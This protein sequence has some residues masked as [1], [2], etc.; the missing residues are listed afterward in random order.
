M[1]HDVFI[2]HSSA[3][4][5][6]ADAICH[7]LENNGIKCWIAPR[8]VTP[9]AEYAEEIMYGIENCKVLLLV[10]SK[11]ANDSKPVGKEVENALRYE[12]TVVPFRIEQVTMRKSFEYYL[13]NL[14]W[15]DAYPDDKEFFGLVKAIRHI[16]GITPPEPPAPAPE[17]EEDLTD[18]GQS[19]APEPPAAELETPVAAAM[20]FCKNCGAAYNPAEDMF[21]LE[22]GTKTTAPIEPPAPKPAPAVPVMEFCINCGTQYDP[23][24]DMF[25]LNCGQKH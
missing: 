2:S 20:E 4:K 25:C 12:K 16:L 3:N 17:P 18:A 23:T 14:H 8:D 6:A 9:G 22:C 15:L 1:A 10:F 13:T 21:C 7:A 24:E 5:K 19:I 11:E